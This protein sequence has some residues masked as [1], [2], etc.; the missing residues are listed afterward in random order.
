MELENDLDKY[1]ARKVNVLYSQSL[2]SITAS[3]LTAVIVLT[4]FWGKVPILGL[5]FWFMFI[6]VISI[7]RFL[8]TF[9]YEQSSVKTSN[10][11]KW[12]KLYTIFTFLSGVLWGTS[13]YFIIL[14][15]NVLYTGFL[16]ICICGL[17]AGSLT[18]HAIIHQ[19]FYAFTLPA[20]IL[21]T[22]YMANMI[23]SE[24]NT[25]IFL[26][27]YF[28]LF[29]FVIERRSN[30]TMN[31]IISLQF[32]NESLVGF[33]GEKEKEV[34]FVKR[35]TSKNLQYYANLEDELIMLR[36]KLIELE[37]KYTSQNS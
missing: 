19:V 12:L 27:L 16:L 5:M 10:Y 8:N 22:I 4:V 15:D 7:F 14:L 18:T 1:N 9:Y 28:S 36:N 11:K 6:L 30:K 25:L 21:F 3:I 33:I 31:H 13:G 37:N 35:T 23:G 29:I 24:F 34:D 20:I 17:L 32:N 2:P 26:Y